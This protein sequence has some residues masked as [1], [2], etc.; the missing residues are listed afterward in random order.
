MAT[1]SQMDAILVDGQTSLARLEAILQ[2]IQ[3]RLEAE[4]QRVAEEISYYPPPIPACD[5]QFNSLL[6]ARSTLLQQIGQVRGMLAQQLTVDDAQDALKWL[7]AHM[8]TSRYL[9]SELKGEI[10]QLTTAL[11]DTVVS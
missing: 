11:S 5:A 7:H 10:R 2:Q 1:R 9:D 8:L 4:K 6:E 3:Q